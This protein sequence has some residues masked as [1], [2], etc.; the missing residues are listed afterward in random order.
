MPEQRAFTAVIQKASSGGAYVRIP[1][2]VEA[3]FGKK[4]VPVTATFDGEPYRGSLV[5]MGGDCHVL[6]VLKDVQ[7]RIG[8]GIGDSVEVKVEEDVAPREVDV[9]ANLAA[10]LADSP[11]AQAAFEALAYT[12]KREYVRWIEEAKRDETRAKRV[13]ETIE[14]LVRGEKRR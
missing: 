11:D 4:R 7:A 5:R 3:V 9:P 10:A 8:K 12:H 13:T 6:G 14:R 2:D 1:F